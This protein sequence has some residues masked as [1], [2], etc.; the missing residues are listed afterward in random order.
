MPEEINKNEIIN[1]IDWNLWLSPEE[2]ELL[3]KIK[4]SNLDLKNWLTKQEKQKFMDNL[5]QD[6]QYSLLLTM[7]QSQEL[8]PYLK[9]AK[10]N[11]EFDSNLIESIKSTEQY[12]IYV[13]VCEKIGE[14][15]NSPDFMIYNIS[16][17]YA[18]KIAEQMKNDWQPWYQEYLDL[19]MNF[20]EKILQKE[21]DNAKALTNLWNTY[22]VKWFLNLDN[23]KN[24]AEDN[25]K[26]ALNFYDRVWNDPDI[27]ANR[28]KINKIL[29]T[30]EKE[31]VLK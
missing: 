5:N 6:F 2:F 4:N 3:K 9:L 18:T 17:V 26:T 22:A 19:A 15:P 20:Q 24:L 27:N 16:S 7:S 13:N 14:T 23:D 8:E 11:K 29:W 31:T 21:P 12:K 28:E 1:W 25:F 30:K 10:E